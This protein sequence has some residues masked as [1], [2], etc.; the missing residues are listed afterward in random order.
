MIHST[1]IVHPSARIG[2]GVEIGPYAIIGEHVS[3]G[4]GTWVGPHAVIE[5]WTE[6]GRENKI[7]QFASV[8]ATPQDLKFHGEKSFLRLGDR[9][10]IRE[11]ATIH[12]GTE[13]GGGET[14]IGDDCLLMAYTH[15]AH[16]CRVGNRVILGNAAT[17]AGHVS[18]DDYAILSALCAIHQFVRIGAHAMIGGGSM[19][20]QDIPPY[21]MA[22][23]DRARPMGINQVGLKR[24]GFSEEIIR[25]I[26]QS[27]KLVFRSGLRIE[28]AIEKIEDQFAASSEVRVFTD[29][30]RT[31]QRGLAR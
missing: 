24:R 30:I 5:G 4:A 6:I 14:V 3:L 31:S 2:E 15:V 9:N 10:I 26:K 12:R 21:V 20:T 29:F 8:G 28:E 7:F 23:G 16:D 1:A 13:G 25:D 17:L 27:Y 11:F 22:Q 19:V 18:L